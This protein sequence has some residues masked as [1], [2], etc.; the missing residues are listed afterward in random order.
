MASAALQQAQHGGVLQPTNYMHAAAI[1]TVSP[2]R[3]RVL[4]MAVEL[5]PFDAIAAA[6]FIAN[7]QQLGVGLGRTH[8]RPGL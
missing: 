5:R 4:Q 1:H 7:Q 3:D 6:M 2:A 8:R